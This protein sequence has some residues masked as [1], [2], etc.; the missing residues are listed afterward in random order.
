MS[1]TFKIAHRLLDQVRADL[2]RRHSFAYERMGFISCCAIGSPSRLVVLADEYHCILDDHYVRDPKVGARMGS[3][4]IR[5]A[6]QVA[7]DRRRGMF[8]IHLHDHFGV[9]A[10]SGV[11]VREHRRFVPDFF[12]VAPAM[13]HGALVLSRNSAT[14]TVCTNLVPTFLPIDEF[15]VVGRPITF[16]WRGR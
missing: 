3:D 5:T 9:P 14:G 7:L 4:A 15:L 10:F 12:S 13:P 16:A 2:T 6:L 8:H 11:D 1:I